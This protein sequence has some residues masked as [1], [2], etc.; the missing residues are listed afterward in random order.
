V[1]VG[2]SRTRQRV[3]GLGLAALI[4]AVWLAIHVAGIFFWRAEAHGWAL[5]ALL[6]AAQTW[7]STGLFITAHDAMHGSLAPGRPDWNRRVGT[8]CLMLYAGLSYRQLLPK[9]AAHH[10]H[11]GSG[12]DP[13]FHAADPCRLLPWFGRFFATYYTHGQFIRISAAGLVYTI[14]LGA[15]PLNILLF[16]A[17][18]AVLAL[19]QLFVFGTYLPHRHGE[20]PFADDHRARS[21]P[22]SGPISLV[23]CFHFG[24]Y[25]HE[26]HLSP[27]TPWWRLPSVRREREESAR[28]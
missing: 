5:A 20:E 11:A 13:D 17:V 21:T 28:S 19:V 6:V 9:H 2:I 7:L 27:G 23:T 18:P 3:A 26:H 8:L 16:W 15:S 4:I 22:V 10:R 25:H 24:G 1:S 12:D 14:V